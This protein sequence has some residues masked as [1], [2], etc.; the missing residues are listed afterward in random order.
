V[1]KKKGERI[2]DTPKKAVE[3]ENKQPV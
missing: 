2:Y 3:E 1:I